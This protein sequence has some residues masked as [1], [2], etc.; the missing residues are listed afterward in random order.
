MKI[1]KTFLYLIA[2]FI[3]ALILRITAA[4]LV[5]VG[6]DEMIYSIIPL[7]IVSAGRLG[8]VEQSIL[9]FYLTDVGYILSEGIT[10][11]S[12]RFPS[13]IFGSIAVFLVYL[14]A[15]EIFKDKKIGLLSALFYATSG[16]ILQYNTEMDMTAFF[17]ILL[18]F[19]FFLKAL[20]EEIIKKWLYLSSL[21]FGLGVLTKSTVALFLPA[22]IF[23]FV[24]YAL[25]HV[26]E[27][28][29]TKDVPNPEVNNPSKYYLN[30]ILKSYLKP[31]II[32]SLIFLVVVSPVF[33]YNYLLYQ[34]KGATDYYFSNILGIGTSVHQGL[35]GKP[36]ELTRL[37]NVTSGLSKT[38][39]KWDFLIFVLGILGLIIATKKYK[40]GSAFTYTSLIFLIGYI[41]GQTG[42]P[43]HFLWIPIVFS[44]F[45]GYAPFWILEKISKRV[46]NIKIESK[47]IFITV[48]IILIVSQGIFL[49]GVYERSKSGSTIPLR[50]MVRE[51]IP[52]DAIVVI[53][54]RIYRGIHAWVFNDRYYLDGTQFVQLM[55]QIAE[56]DIPKQNLPLY[57]VEC[58][59]GSHCGWKPEDLARIQDTGESLSN[60]LIPQMEKVAELL[61]Q[62]TFNIY[63]GSISAPT[64]IYDVIEQN[65]VFWFYPVGWHDPESAI[66]SYSPKGFGKLVNMLGFI[67]LYLDLIIAI[68]SI[69]FV[70]YIAWRKSAY[71]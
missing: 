12:F 53:D 51:S 63:R 26:K 33:A 46:P 56:S 59:E 54:P 57:Y 69:L 24:L 5:D 16:F 1:T 71:L 35:E 32:A 20:K 23:V 18:S 61:G 49:S 67:I 14:I 58:G 48:I 30:M 70:P 43:T 17:F 65:K 37:W 68:L 45:A 28:A 3:I 25:K 62:P 47:H 66:D 41:A 38:L 7:N 39:L 27:H 13:I 4:S 64:Q 60:Q 55:N 8:T 29:N 52:K 22:Y 31:I 36:W 6:T 40:Y 44:I 50:S 15:L 19:L 9:Y 11:L 42:S 21:F 10:S 34:E 2:I